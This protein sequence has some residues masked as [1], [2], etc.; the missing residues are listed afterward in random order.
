MRSEQWITMLIHWNWNTY[1]I[2]YPWRPSLQT[3]ESHHLVWLWLVINWA[4]HPSRH[5]SPL[6]RDAHDL[7]FWSSRKSVTTQIWKSYVFPSIHLRSTIRCFSTLG[8]PL[9]FLFQKGGRW[10]NRPDIELNKFEDDVHTCYIFLLFSSHF[11]LAQ[12]SDFVS[13]PG[14]SFRIS[15]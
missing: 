14:P 10:Q 4:G 8:H 7:I 12:R 6:M 13:V 9:I 2:C 5:V 1:H 15:D 11:A 3:G